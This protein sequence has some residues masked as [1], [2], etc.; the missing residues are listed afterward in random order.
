MDSSM[1]SRG[2]PGDFSFSSDVRR[3]RQDAI[4]MDGA[5]SSF[6]PINPFPSVGGSKKSLSGAGSQRV[7]AKNIM[8]SNNSF[9]GSSGVSNKRDR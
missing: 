9:I 5:N 1:R 3:G 2:G 8:D 4:Q 6:D 7:S